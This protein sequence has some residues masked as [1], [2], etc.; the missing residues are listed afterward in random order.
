MGTH[1]LD[2]KPGGRIH[3]FDFKKEILNSA[4]VFGP[5]TNPRLSFTYIIRGKMVQPRYLFAWTIIVAVIS[6]NFD[7]CNAAIVKIGDRKP[8]MDLSN[9][10]LDDMDKWLEDDEDDID[11]LDD[12]N[13]DDDLD[14]DELDKWLDDDSYDLNMLDR[15]LTPTKWLKRQVRQLWRA[16]DQIKPRIKDNED[17]IDS[18]EADVDMNKMGIQ[19]NSKNIT[20][21]EEDID[22]NEEAIGDNYD[23]IK[24]NEE[25]IENLTISVQEKIDLHAEL[26]ANNTN[27]TK[28]NE[29]MIEQNKVAIQ[30][31]LD[32]ILQLTNVPRQYLSFG[33]LDDE[34]T[35]TEEVYLI[36]V[37]E[38]NNVTTACNHSTLPSTLKESH[39]FEWDDTLLVCS[40]FRSGTDKKRLDCYTWDTA[41]NTWV[42]FTTP[43]LD[44]ATGIQGNIQSVQIPGVGIWFT[45]AKGDTPG[46]SSYLLQ[47]DGTWVQKVWPNRPRTKG[48]MIRYNDTHIAG[49]GGTVTGENS[50][51]IDTYDFSSNEFKE[52]VAT[53]EFNRTQHQ[54]ALIPEGDNGNPTV[55]ILGDTGQDKDGATVITPWAM[56]MTLWDTV[57]NEMTLIPHP[58]GYD[59]DSDTYRFSRPTM[60]TWDQNTILLAASQVFEGDP[61]TKTV[62]M[63]Q[64]LYKFGEGWTSLGPIVPS[65]EAAYEYDIYML[66]NPALGAYDS[67]TKCADP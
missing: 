23:E 12:I 15:K 11:D 2:F 41:T 16:L 14:L 47:E 49:I 60:A 64:W 29:M 7:N 40:S 9:L 56:E 44:G 3:F 28:E 21:N 66:D 58:P 67:L 33:G 26:I 42:Q 24:M 22:D 48:C 50:D 45:S 19:T 43:G 10:D 18:L 35:V 61:A 25:K 8:A 4:L 63:E 65:I 46:D 31:N 57:T 36:T 32:E 38:L 13:D 17:A 30:A 51:K 27:A 59:G 37:D 53:L 55:V 62:L 6:L 52:N 20:D 39:A 5:K 34:N 1:H 54:C